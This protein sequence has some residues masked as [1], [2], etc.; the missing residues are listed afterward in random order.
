MDCK[1][2]ALFDFVAEGSSELSITAGEYLTITSG[3]DG[4]DWW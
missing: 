3:T 1:A 2:R 4:N